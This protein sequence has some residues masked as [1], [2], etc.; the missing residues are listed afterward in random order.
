MSTMATID[1]SQVDRLIA[2][3]DA[4]PLGTEGRVAVLVESPAPEER[5][6]PDAVTVVPGVGFAGDHPRKSFWKGRRI[7]GRE[8]TAVSAEAL[9]LFGTAPARIGDNLV[10]EGFD[11]RALQPGDRVQVGTVILERSPKPHRPCTKFR[12]R[13]SP[14]AFA[15]VSQAGYRGALFTVVKGGVIRRGDA[16]RVQPRPDGG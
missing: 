2:Q 6:T 13:T 4:L 9:R 10:V 11:L 1:R 12:D 8:V 3:L 16:I 7:P 14:E 5:Q 15:A